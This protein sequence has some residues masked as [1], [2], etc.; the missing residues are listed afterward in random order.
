MPKVTID[1][2]LLAGRSR[3]DCL[4]VRDLVQFAAAGP[5]RR[6]WW[7]D[8]NHFREAA[9]KDKRFRKLMASPDWEAIFAAVLAL[10][11]AISA[12]KT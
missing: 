9:A 10:I 4:R 12:G 1:T 6:T 11:E 5:S 3:K 7:R 2:E 8:E